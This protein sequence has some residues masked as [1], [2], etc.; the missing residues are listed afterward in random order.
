MRLNFVNWRGII[1]AW[2]IPAIVAIVG[3]VL[4]QPVLAHLPSPAPGTTALTVEQL[5]IG[6]EVVNGF[7]QAYYQNAG[8][9]TYVTTGNHNHYSVSGRGNYLVWI[10]DENQVSQIE[11]YNLSTGVLTT[12]A[13]S[14]TNSGPRVDAGKVVWQK[15]VTDKWQIMYYNGSTTTQ[16]TAGTDPAFR[17]D[18]EGTKIA[19]ATRTVTDFYSHEYNT[20]TT[21]TTSTKYNSPT[22]EPWPTISGG[23]VNL[24]WLY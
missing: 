2:G 11:M 8:V 3:F 23:A 19:Y 20:S 14:G 7:R 1:R 22:G 13:T 24:S 12:L 16:L 17:P 15:W 18:I 4:V 9:R 6:A 10:V 5:T 21:I